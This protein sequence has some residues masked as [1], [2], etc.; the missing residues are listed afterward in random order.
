MKRFAKKHNFSFRYVVDETQ[1]V[2]RAYDAV[3]TPEF[4]GFDAA[5]ELQ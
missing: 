4:F 3:C 1:D 2:G 5:L